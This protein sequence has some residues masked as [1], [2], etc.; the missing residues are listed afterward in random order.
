MQLDVVTQAGRIWPDQSTKRRGD[1]GPEQTPATG[2]SAQH[3]GEDIAQFIHRLKSL[4]P[5]LSK[6]S[7]LR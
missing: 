7:R 3:A 5:A 4:L 2:L 6:P 1:L